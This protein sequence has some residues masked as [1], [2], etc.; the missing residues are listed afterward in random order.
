M[1]FLNRFLWAGGF[2]LLMAA[3]C[4]MA[5]AA[6]LHPAAKAPVTQ[7][8]AR[9]I[10]DRITSRYFIVTKTA[11]LSQETA[12]KVDQGSAWSN[13]LWGQ[14][15]TA[16]GVVRVDLGVDLS[17]LAEKDVTVDAASKTVKIALPDATI[18]GAA[19]YGD[20]EVKSQQ[21]V[22]QYLLKNDPNGDQNRARDQLV[23][24]AKTA[25]RQDTQLFADAHRDAE[26]LL[27]LIIEGTGYQLVVP[28]VDQ[29]AAAK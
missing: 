1:T 16:H 27:Q 11:Y 20:V 23:A 13:L 19:T 9:T 15:L 3:L 26:K 21:G 28:A 25:V 14:T 6:L 12:I 10:I 2:F 29:P 22:L 18:M 4:A 8:T 7:V 5:V 17:G 24:D